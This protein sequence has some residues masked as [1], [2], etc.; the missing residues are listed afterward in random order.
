MEIPRGSKPLAPTYPSRFEGLGSQGRA[1][2]LAAAR[3][4][5]PRPSLDVH[6]SFELELLAKSELHRKLGQARHSSPL[7]VGAKAEAEPAR[8]ATTASFIIV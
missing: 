8:A 3:L 7:V 2:D 6:K 4:V 1:L 5:D